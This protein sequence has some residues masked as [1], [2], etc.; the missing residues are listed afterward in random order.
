[1]VAFKQV[2][3]GKVNIIILFQTKFFGLVTRVLFHLI[4]F[5]QYLLEGL[6]EILVEYSINYRIESTVAVS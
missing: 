5:N 1:M 6:S 2:T 4:S 3:L